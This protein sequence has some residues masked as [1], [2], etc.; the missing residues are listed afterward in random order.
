MQK[1]GVDFKQFLTRMLDKASSELKGKIIGFFEEVTPVTLN[2]VAILGYLQHHGCPTPLLDWTFD[3]NTAL[4]FGVDGVKQNS[5]LRA[6]HKYFS[7]YFLEEEYFEGGSMREILK[8]ALHETSER[9][10]NKAIAVI[11]EGD[12]KLMTEMKVHFKDRSFFDKEK[13]KQSVFIKD[14]ISLEH[15]LDIPL[16]YFSDRDKDSEIAFSLTNSANIKK[17]NG[18]FT[19]NAHFAK[20]VEVAGNEEYGKENGED[21]AKDY[22][23]C[24]CYNINKDLSEYIQRK[25]ETIGINK[26]TMYPDKDIDLKYIYEQSKP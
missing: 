16:T 25:L 7:V 20:P 12:E 22:M 18:V 17:Q 14:L 24:K 6:I 9:Y 13:L 21:K 8:Y 3:F 1:K 19:W 11:A 5:D 2:D 4:F 26:D 23:F 10:K 15:I